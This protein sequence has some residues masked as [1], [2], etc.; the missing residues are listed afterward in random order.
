MVS[1]DG[2]KLAWRFRV[3]RCRPAR[4]SRPQTRRQAPC[5][6]RTD[7]CFLSS[8]EFSTAS[9]RLRC[10]RFPS[11]CPIPICDDPSDMEAAKVIA[12]R[13]AASNPKHR[14]I[15]LCYF[16]RMLLLVLAWQ[17]AETRRSRS[18]SPSRPKAGLSAKP[19]VGLTKVRL[20]RSCGISVENRLSSVTAVQLSRHDAESVPR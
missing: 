19:S 1:S 6:G 20:A 16:G 2:S 12:L 7:V 3:Q 15:S 8:G 10:F 9:V 14:A 13:I 4:G 18:Q 11:T 5:M 17:V